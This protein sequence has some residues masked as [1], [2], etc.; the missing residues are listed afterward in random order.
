M[1]TLLLPV[2]MLSTFAFAAPAPAS[3]L[4][5]FGRCLKTKGATFYGASW[6]PHCRTQKQTLGEA[7][8]GVRYVECAPGG[9]RSK[10]ADECETAGVRSYPTWVFGDGSRASGALSVASLASKT[11]CPA[12]SGGATSSNKKSTPAPSATGPRI[13]EVPREK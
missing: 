10:T 12:P 5:E 4:G 2:A 1:K 9:D 13:L 3:D 11:G 7:M 6:C 8:S